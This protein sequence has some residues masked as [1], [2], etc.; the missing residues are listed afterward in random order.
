MVISHK[1]FLKL[2]H[3]K[4]VKLVKAGG[5]KLLAFVEWVNKEDFAE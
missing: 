4:L 1:D 5:Q 2:Q 3:P